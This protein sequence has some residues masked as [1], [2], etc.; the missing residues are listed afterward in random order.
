M[1]SSDFL[2]SCIKT[3]LASGGDYADAFVESGADT[4]IVFDDGKVKSI[5]TG[6]VAGVGLRVITGRNYVYLYASDPTEVRLREL[7]SAMAEA[8][9]AGKIGTMCALPPSPLEGGRHRVAR[10]PVKAD[11]G[12]K[13]DMLKRADAAARSAAPT[14]SQVTAT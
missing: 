3:A 9:A 8:V 14:I 7:A 13:I 1:F 4:L 6:L 5:S 12:T 10:D 2:A 11:L